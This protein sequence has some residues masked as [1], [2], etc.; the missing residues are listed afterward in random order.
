MHSVLENDQEK[1]DEGNIIQESLNRGIGAFTPD[2][3]FEKFVKNYAMTKSIMGESLVRAISGYNP[4]YIEKNIGIPEFQRELKKRIDEK[5][6]NMKRDK[7]IDKEGLITEKGIELASAILCIQE[8][9]KIVPRGIYGERIHKKTSIYGDKIEVRN[10]RKGD[11]YKDI[12]I[13]K[14]VKTAIRRGHETIRPEDLKTNERGSKGEVYLIYGLDSSGSMKGDKISMCKKAGVALAYQAIK[15]KDKVGLIV[16]GTEIEKAVEPTIDFT[17]LLKAITR[18]K[19]AAETD[20]AVTINRAT[21]MFPLTEVTKHLL[22]LTDAL[23]TKGDEPEKETL[24]AAATARAQ[25]ITISV[26]GIN[27]DNKGKKLAEKLVEAGK[28][29]LY[30]VKDLKEINQIVLEDYYRVI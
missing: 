6:E 16:F 2:L 29:K 5:L 21:Q 11:R 9:D 7:V 12:A 14:S 15:H 8:L 28:G 30:V 1:I 20:I 25:G 23:P 24:K 19:A 17:M 13:K 22:L 27:L 3:L 18:I 4:D 26:I 10:Y